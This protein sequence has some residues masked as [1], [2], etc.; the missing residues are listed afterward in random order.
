LETVKTGQ[1][2]E[3]DLVAHQ[4]YR[5]YAAF[6]AELLERTTPANAELATLP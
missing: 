1:Y 4:L 3:P 5:Q 6:Y 2:Y